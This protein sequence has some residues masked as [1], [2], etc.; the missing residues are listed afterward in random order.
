M[1]V[2]T[3][4]GDR[5]IS[6]CTPVRGAKYG[7]LTRARA[8]RTYIEAA[9]TGPYVP[10]CSGVRCGQCGAR[11]RL[12]TAPNANSITANATKPDGGSDANASIFD[13]ALGAN[14]QPHRQ[15]VLENGK[16]YIAID[17]TA[18]VRRWN[19]FEGRRDTALVGASVRGDGTHSGGRNTEA[20][21]RRATG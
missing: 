17:T 2:G 18:G 15:R 20:N 9:Q 3:Q 11:A 14:S 7:V 5:D 1:A 4:R 19:T 16:G 10:V 13:R 12:S 21:V 8:R 6:R